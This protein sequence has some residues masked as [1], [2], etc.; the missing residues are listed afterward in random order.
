[1]QRFIFHEGQPYAVSKSNTA[2]QLDMSNENRVILRGYEIL[3]GLNPWK[4]VVLTK[5][6]DWALVQNRALVCFEVNLG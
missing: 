5:T 3:Q 1:M 2:T 6:R 4:Y